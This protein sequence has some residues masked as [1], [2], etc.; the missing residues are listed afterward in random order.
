MSFIYNDKACSG[1]RYDSPVVQ[2]VYSSYNK[3]I[4]ILLIMN[5]RTEHQ[6]VHKYKNLVGTIYRD[7]AKNIWK[8]FK[9]SDFVWLLCKR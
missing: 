9:K 2:P 7:I 4:G 5:L 8:S 1:M 3:I 6:Y